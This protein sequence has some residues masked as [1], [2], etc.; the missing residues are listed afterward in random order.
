M[1]NISEKLKFLIQLSKTE[2]VLNRKFS[3]QQ[4]LGFGELAVLYAISQAPEG[5]I[6]RIDLADEVGL[7]ASAVTRLLIPLEKIG[8]IK[9]EAHQ[10][11]AR[12]S[13]AIMT[14]PGKEMFENAIT[15]LEHKCNDLIPDSEASSIPQASS[16]L[17]SIAK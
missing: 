11:D 2:A 4:G 6:R 16:L 10:R 13:Y 7:T 8:V 5:R 15:A 14:R 12:V 1:L 3:G 17:R 9:R